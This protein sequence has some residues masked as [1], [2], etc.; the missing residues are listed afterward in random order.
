M[1]QV[2]SITSAGI[3]DSVSAPGSQLSLAAHSPRSQRIA[4]LMSWIYGFL[5]VRHL[6]TRPGAVEVSIA[7]LVGVRHWSANVSGFGGAGMF[8]TMLSF[9]LSTQ[10]V[11][12]SLGG[13]PALSSSP[14]LFRVRNVVLLGAAIWSFGEA[15]TNRARIRM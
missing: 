7:L 8:L 6:S 2:E 3:G 1:T 11:R 13:F 10:A 14:D 4:Q 9:F 12:Q 5:T 15:W